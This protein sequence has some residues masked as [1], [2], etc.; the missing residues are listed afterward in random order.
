MSGKGS[1]RKGASGERELAAELVKAGFVASRNARNGL[2]AEDVAHDI[3]G[4]HVEV[5]RQERLA[6]PAWIKQSELD[7]PEGRTPVVMYR[8]SRQ[9]WRVVCTLEHYLELQNAA[10]SQARLAESDTGT[11]QG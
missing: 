1:R 3:P 6:L 8:Q 5:K 4:V 2:S 10:R 9:P 11:G 7:C